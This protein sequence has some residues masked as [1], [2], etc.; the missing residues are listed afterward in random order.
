[1]KI[2]QD[3]RDYAAGLGVSAEQALEQGLEAKAVEFRR[4]GAEVYRKA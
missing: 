4:Q 2:T 3:V 1:M